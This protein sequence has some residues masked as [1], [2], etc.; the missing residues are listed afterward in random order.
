MFGQLGW[1]EV[2]V[3]IVVGL[4][5]FGPE[6]LP[7]VAKD[8]GKMLRQL[9]AMANGVRDDIKSELGPEVADL[10]LASLNPRTFVAKHLLGDD[11]ED[12]T[13]GSPNG[14]ANGSANGSRAS[15]RPVGTDAP[16]PRREVAPR[17]PSA[18]GTPWDDDAT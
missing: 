1:G 12:E 7:G 3:I 15:A 11:E 4:F 10:D 14:S 17:P 16:T 13:A 2:L 6:R 9:R 5:V 18:P 8:A